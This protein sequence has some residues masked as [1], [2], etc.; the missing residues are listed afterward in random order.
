MRLEMQLQES[1]AQVGAL[2]AQLERQSL[3]DDDQSSQFKEM[4]AQLQRTII[5]NDSLR[6]QADEARTMR[7]ELKQVFLCKASFMVELVF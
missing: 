6:S 5:E 4:R 2:T 1:Q 3:K 7:D